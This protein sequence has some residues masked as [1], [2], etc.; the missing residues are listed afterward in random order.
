[1]YGISLNVPG[2]FGVIVGVVLLFICVFSGRDVM[3]V[4]GATGAVVFTVVVSDST[5]VALR[6]KSRG[7][8]LYFAMRS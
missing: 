8:T 6:I 3:G 7:S 5:P 2:T 1:M 4:T